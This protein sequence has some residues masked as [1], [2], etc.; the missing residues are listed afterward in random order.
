M[1]QQTTTKEPH[2]TQ[3]QSSGRPHT[4][5]VRLGAAGELKKWDKKIGPRSLA[6]A[7]RWR[8]PPDAKQQV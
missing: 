6:A 3:G 1:S 4:Q 2:M 7:E 5:N 8:K